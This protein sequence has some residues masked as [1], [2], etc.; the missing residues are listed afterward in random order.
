MISGRH[1]SIGIALL[2][3]LSH[4]AALKC[5]ASRSPPQSSSAAAASSVATAGDDGLRHKSCAASPSLHA[6]RFLSAFSSFQTLQK[7]QL[8]LAAANNASA[9]VLVY[10]ICCGEMGNRFLVR[11]VDFVLFV[12]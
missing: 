9:R 3:L 4:E 1:L 6:P 10:R 7:E 11:N 2:L 12:F 5:Q 8:L